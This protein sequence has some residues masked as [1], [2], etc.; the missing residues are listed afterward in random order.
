[1][2]RVLVFMFTAL[3]IWSVSITAKAITEEEKLQDALKTGQIIRLHIIAAGDDEENQRIKLCV[4]DKVLTAWRDKMTDIKSCDDMMDFL[5]DN[6]QALADAALAA[7]REEGF[8]GGVS[9]QVGVF[10][11]PDRWYGSVLVPAGYYNSLR[12][13]LG[14]GEGKNWWCVLFPNL[15]LSLASSDTPPAEQPVPQ[16]TASSSA[17]TEP[18]PEFSWWVGRLF[19]AW[20]LL[21]PV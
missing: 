6:R 1:M 5:R 14:S 16:P 12:I 17:Q 11:F 3:L 7:A 10:T 18:Q 19:S 20:P 13:V 4:R 2:R 8:E 9:A 21:P 15:C